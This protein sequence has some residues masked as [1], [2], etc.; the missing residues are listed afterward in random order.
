MQARIK[1]YFAD[2]IPRILFQHGSPGLAHMDRAVI[3][4]G[5]DPPPKPATPTMA[6]KLSPVGVHGMIVLMRDEAARNNM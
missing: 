6:V 1:A 2:L 5:V 3:G 4:E